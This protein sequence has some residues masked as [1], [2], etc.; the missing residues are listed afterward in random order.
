MVLAVIILQLISSGVNL[1]Q[2]DPFFVTAMWGAI[3]LALI[4][5][6]HFTA[7]GRRRVGWLNCTPSAQSKEHRRGATPPIRPAKGQ[8]ERTKP[9]GQ[10]D[11]RLRTGS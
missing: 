1:L 5:V 8:Y 9:F 10:C 4:A 6:N 2:V 3:I 11:L 7:A